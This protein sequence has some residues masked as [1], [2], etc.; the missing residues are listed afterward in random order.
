[1]FS[2]HDFRGSNIMVTEP[3]DEILFCDLE[4]SAYGWRGFDFGTILVEWG[5]T[6]SEFGKS[7]KDIQKYP[8]DETIKG[9][10]KIYVEESIRLLG[11][12][13]A[14]NPVN[15][16]DH[17]LREAKLF[18]LAAIMFLV[19]FSIKNDVSDGISLPIDKKLFMQWGE[20]AYEG[21]FYMKEMFGF[22]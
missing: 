13:F 20:N 16:I 5:R 7:E 10:L 18:S 8:N 6:F 15:S 22:Q 12:K 3:D 4:Y 19:V 14:N 9:L 17:I 11:P 1:M 21:Y 2:H